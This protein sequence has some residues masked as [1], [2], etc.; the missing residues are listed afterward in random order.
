MGEGAANVG[1]FAMTVLLVARDALTQNLAKNVLHGFLKLGLWMKRCVGPESAYTN[2]YK[3]GLVA[4]FR[5][6]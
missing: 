6:R 1:S 5:C 4:I 2:G 3:S